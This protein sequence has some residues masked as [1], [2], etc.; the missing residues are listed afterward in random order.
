MML[1]RIKIKII[2]LFHSP[3]LLYLLSAFTAYFIFQYNLI[4]DARNFNDLTWKIILTILQGIILG[5][6]YSLWLK[7][8]LDKNENHHLVSTINSLHQTLFLFWFYPLHLTVG[9]FS[10]NRFLPLIIGFGVVLIILN[11]YRQSHLS[12]RFTPKTILTGL[13]VL[14]F[15]LFSSWIY[16]SYPHSELILSLKSTEDTKLM[17][18]ENL[19][20]K[21]PSTSHYSIAKSDDYQVVTFKLSRLS[22]LR[23]LRIVFT[24]PSSILIKELTLR[25][26]NDKITL[27]P[28]QILS[29]FNSNEGFSR[30]ETEDDKLLVQTDK[31]EVHLESTKLFI[32]TITELDQST[33]AT[34]RLQ[35]IVFLFFLAIVVLISLL[36]SASGKLNFDLLIIYFVIYLIFISLLKTYAEAVVFNG[37][38]FDGPFQLFNNL[39][40][41]ADTQIPGKDYQV[42]HGLGSGYLHLLPYLLLGK[43][44]LASEIARWGVSLLVFPLVNYLFLRAINLNKRAAVLLTILLSLMIPLFDLTVLSEPANSLISI[45]S[46]FPVVIAAIFFKYQ[47]SFVNRDII[48]SNQSNS[49]VKRIIRNHLW[50]M[51]AAILTVIAF[52]F[53]VEH[54]LATFGALFITVLLFPPG[55]KTGKERLISLAFYMISTALSLC[56]FY[57]LLS[58]PYFIQTLNYAL[59]DVP[60]DQFWYFGTPP[61]NFV[62]NFW[63]LINPNIVA[64]RILLA[65]FILLPLCVFSYFKD[66]AKRYLFSLLIFLLSEGLITATLPY[67]GIMSLNYSTPLMRIN[68]L[69]TIALGVYWTSLIQP[70]LAKLGKQSDS[71]SHLAVKTEAIL[72]GII[73][74]LFTAYH[75]PN[76][77]PEI[78]N[79]FYSLQRFSTAK[80]F[81]GIRLIPK[82][83]KDIAVLTTVI[84]RD[85]ARKQGLWSTYSGLLEAEYDIFNPAFDYIIHALGENGRQDY[86][87][88][89]NEEKPTFVIT[90]KKSF[91]Y[92]EWLQNTTWPFYETLLLNYHPIDELSY[93]LIWKKDEDKKW[94]PPSDY[95]FEGEISLD[96]YSEIEIPIDHAKEKGSILVLNIEYQI[97]NP[98]KH[99]PLLKDLPRYLLYPY[100]C[101]SKTAIALPPYKNALSFPLI[102][103]AN[104]SP[105][106]KVR[107]EPYLSGVSLDIKKMQYRYLKIDDVNTQA[108]IN[109]KY[110]ESSQETD[111]D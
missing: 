23:N 54:G 93:G 27:S 36:P 104:Q 97:K 102:L 95:D 48:R 44:F 18:Q 29:N 35:V 90:A 43:N 76:I 106:I 3:P 87:M 30:L 21:A 79:K 82:W 51:L 22:N 60:A 56:L 20:D 88:K 26:N 64:V 5:G 9:S 85:Q 72:M 10:L 61:N 1:K 8:K 42:F 45:R 31:D 110:V 41:L 109:S 25:T 80:T 75:L 81:Q 34:E 13:I 68:L 19:K 58:G 100:N 92:E 16:M 107:I 91:A 55:Q 38:P 74:I 28:A 49:R 39:R 15:A 105:L 11:Y 12:P 96:H 63:D 4:N 2:E 84:P 52:F 71:T 57:F 53:S 65:L 14:F 83:E 77:F 40:R 101:R 70:Q 66:T 78:F 32:D 111:Q 67:L 62:K 69:V 89:F 73:F 7:K 108:L 17:I 46:F 37:I 103:K 50:E 33:I 99:L 94:Q 59:K 86:L 6:L 47:S 98:Y 24:N